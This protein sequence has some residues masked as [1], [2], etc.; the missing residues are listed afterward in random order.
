MAAGIIGFTVAAASLREF[1]IWL[2]ERP[3]PGKEYR[4]LVTN[5][6]T[7]LLFICLLAVFLI[8]PIREN[9]RLFVAYVIPVLFLYVYL[10]YWLFPVKI[11]IAAGK[12]LP[13]ALTPS[14]IAQLFF[15][16]LAGVHFRRFLF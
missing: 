4:V 13:A 8:H 16:T 5:T 3:G 14:V 9:S 2:I 7:S 1:I 11:K 10:T 15:S 6:A 12:K